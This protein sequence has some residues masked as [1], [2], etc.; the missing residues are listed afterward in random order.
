M[1]P[2]SCHDVH[3]TQQ[4]RNHACM[5]LPTAVV[6]CRQISLLH[7]SQL[8]CGGGPELWV[9]AQVAD[10]IEAACAGTTGTCGVLATCLVDKGVMLQCLAGSNTAPCAGTIVMV[11]VLNA[12][13]PQDLLPC[14]E[15]L[16]SCTCLYQPPAGFK[17][18]NYHK[19]LVMMHT[20]GPCRPSYHVLAHQEVSMLPA[21]YL[22]RG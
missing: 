22:R 11:V 6:S 9:E 14:E 8:A 7:P 21:S 17:P 4:L 15:S 20:L 3:P 5:L 2:R 19:C 16:P 12:P 1:Q 18:C 13:D 10:C